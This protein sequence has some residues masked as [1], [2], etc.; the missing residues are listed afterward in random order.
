MIVRFGT[1]LVCVAAICALA[2]SSAHGSSSRDAVRTWRKAHEKVIVADFVT[3]LSMPNV[4]TNVADA[5]KNAAYI[6]GQL[7]ARG[8]QT[9]LLS[10]EPGTPPSVFA[11]MKIPGAKRTVIF[12]AHYDGQPIGQRGWITNPF[13]PSMRTALPEAKTVDWQNS[14]GPLDPDWRLFARAAGDDKA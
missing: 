1:L 4:A 13:Q 6:E 14:T 3:L 9:R 12:Y 8:F 10:A 7:K 5:E 11:E 2:A